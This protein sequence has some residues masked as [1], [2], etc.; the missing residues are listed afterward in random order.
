MIQLVREMEEKNLPSQEKIERAAEILHQG[1]LVVFPTETV[2]G[3]GADCHNPAAVQRIFSTKG[4]PADHPLIIHLA[5]AE[6][7]H[8]YAVDIPAIAE[9]LAQDFWPGP[10]TLILKRHPQINPLVT[11][12]QDTLAVRVPAHPV[13]QALLQSFGRG[14]AAPS[15]NRFGRISPTTAQHARDELSGQINYLLDGGPCDL[16]IESTI[17]NLTGPTP[18]VLRPGSITAAMLETITGPLAAHP[19]ASSPR[20]PGNLDSHYAP[21]TATYLVTK[22]QLQQP[23]FINRE[24]GSTGVLAI[25]QPA[26][27]FY[28]Q[29]LSLPD[30][31][32][33]YARNLYAALRTLDQA[34]LSCILIQQPPQ[35][36]EWLGVNDRL[37]RAARCL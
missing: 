3:L 33:G 2:Y 21:R 1:G 22:Q 31:A 8:D 20:A 28:R 34:G 9:Q 26:Q 32:A 36:A 10:L 25:N 30:D 13:A 17:I 24:P 27:P 23:D 29:W 6:Q 14:V 7:L 19:S 5:S 16:G 18:Q 4:R 35:Q 15:A 12:G 11:G 37:R